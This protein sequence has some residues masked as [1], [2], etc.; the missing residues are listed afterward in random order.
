MHA[1]DLHDDQPGAALGARALIGDQ[2]FGRQ[3]A[4]RQIGVVAGREDPVAEFGG[5]DL[6]WGEEMGEEFG[7][8]M[9]KAKRRRQRKRGDCGVLSPFEQHHLIAHETGAGIFAKTVF[10]GEPKRRFIQRI[11]DAHASSLKPCAS[12]QCRAAVTASEA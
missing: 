3:A 1:D 9:L 8:E 2:R 10:G 6:E 12:S 7:H 5:L 4:S 11:D